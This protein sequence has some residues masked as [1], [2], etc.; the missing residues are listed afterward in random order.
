MKNNSI[1]ITLILGLIAGISHVDI[2]GYTVRMYNK[3]SKVTFKSNEIH[4][5]NTASW[6]PDSRNEKDLPPTTGYY[7]DIYKSIKC[8]G[9]CFDWFEIRGYKFYIPNQCSDV[10]IEI[11]DNQVLLN[12]NPA[13]S[14]GDIGAFFKDIGSVVGEQIADRFKDTQATRSI[15]FAARMAAYEVALQT[16]TGVLT[17][18]KELAQVTLQGAQETAKLGT[19]AANGFLQGVE[20]T[21]DGI[22]QFSDD[23]AKGVLEAAKQTGVGVLQGT[24]WVVNNTLGQFDINKIHYDGNLQD[25]SK[26]VLG[27]VLVEAQV[28]KPI[29]FHMNLDPKNVANSVASIA[30]DIFNTLKHTLIDPLTPQLTHVKENESQLQKNVQKLGS[31]TPPAEIEKAQKKAQEVEEKMAHLTEQQLKLAQSAKGLEQTMKDLDSKT[32]DQLIQH[33]DEIMNSNLTPAQKRELRLFRD[34]L[35]RK[36]LE[37]PTT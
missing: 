10:T 36:K 6:C 21:A 27:N 32:N 22:L 35:V 2:K 23:A 28:V 31:L 9:T 17:A 5:H 25:L 30:T 4:V 3:T 37:Q 1:Y 20:Q 13:R 15:D 8:R 34:Q 18:A 26:G 24:T 12:G 11:N 7:E 16:A 14:Y 29:S 19:Q 33:I